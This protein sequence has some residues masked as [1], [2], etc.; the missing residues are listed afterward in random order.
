[1]TKFKIKKDIFK[2]SYGCYSA[3]TNWYQLCSKTNIYYITIEAITVIFFMI[4]KKECILNLPLFVTNQVY[5][6][7]TTSI[8]DVC[9]QG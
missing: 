2:I 8:N 5:A 3:E 9:A 6:R 4:N 7:E 1:M